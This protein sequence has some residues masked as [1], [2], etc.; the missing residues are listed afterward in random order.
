MT[1][2]QEWENGAQ[3]WVGGEAACLAA[4]DRGM[5]PFTAIADFRG[6]HKLARSSL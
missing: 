4:R 2:V 1:L 5:P 3:F 6:D